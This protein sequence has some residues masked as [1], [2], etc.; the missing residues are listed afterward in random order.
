M[1]LNRTFTTILLFIQ[2]VIFWLRFGQ[3]RIE[4]IDSIDGR[5]CEYAFYDRNNRCIGW[6]AY[7]CYQEDPESFTALNGTQ[8][9]FQKVRFPSQYRGDNK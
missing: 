2:S 1:E 6:W 4:I 5:P 7:G 8:Y 9:M 3:V